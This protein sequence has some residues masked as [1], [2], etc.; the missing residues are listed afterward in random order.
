M[1]WNDLYSRADF[2]FAGLRE[3]AERVFFPLPGLGVMPSSK[4]VR[5]LVL[6]SEPSGNW[7][8]DPTTGTATT[9]RAE[10]MVRGAD[11]L[12]PFRNFDEQRG[13]WL[14][15]YA[16]DHWLIDQASFANR[17]RI[18]QFLPKS[19]A[20]L[21]QAMS[22]VPTDVGDFIRERRAFSRQTGRGHTALTPSDG[23]RK[24]LVAYRFACS[25]IRA[26]M[27]HRALS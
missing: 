10:M 13:D 22:L 2:P 17:G 9:E 12:Q 4:S 25:G 1:I 5:F 24:F 23:D 18:Y 11:G 7:A 26:Q 14:F 15:Q 27:N 3:R 8:D 16:I 21:D 6:G 20:D 19:K